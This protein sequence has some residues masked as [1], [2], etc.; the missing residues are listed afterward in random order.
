M[1]WEI[2]L[3]PIG[4]WLIRMGIPVADIVQLGFPLKNNSI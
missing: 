4:P 1:F 3:A 2:K